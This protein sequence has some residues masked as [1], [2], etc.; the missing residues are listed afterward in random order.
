MQYAL[1]TGLLVYFEN[2]GRYDWMRYFR[3]QNGLDLRWTAAKE[4]MWS[5]RFR[6]EGISRP[7]T[8]EVIRRSV[9]FVRFF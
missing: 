7:V 6:Q 3:G 8:I 4:A 5:R 9:E 2:Y 1:A